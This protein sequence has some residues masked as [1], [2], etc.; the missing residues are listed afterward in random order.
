MNAPRHGLHPRQK[1]R[2]ALERIVAQPSPVPAGATAQVGTF[3]LRT[4]LRL[5]R[6]PEQL[7]DILVT[8]V[9]FVVIFT[10]LF[11]GALAGSPAAYLQFLL[12]GILVQTMVFTTIHTGVNL[13]TDLSK[14]VY[15]RFRSMPLWAPAP[16][17]GAMLGDTLRYTIAAVIVFAIGFVM[18]FRAEGGLSGLL[19]SVL[20][21]NL[22]AFGLGWIFIAMALVIR[23]P[24]T[25]MN[26]S[27]L[28][29]M[30]V[31][32]ASNIYVHADTM[33]PWLSAI[34]AVNPVTLLV[35]ALRTVLQDGTAPLEIA[36]ALIAPLALTVVGA[37]LVMRLY[38]RER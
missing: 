11:G 26:M 19:L 37:P 28:L 17:V 3:A 32:F 23:T 31:T 1:A 5:R 10:Y 33:P 18:G 12:P 6:E 9:M 38:R 35:T 25:L 22:F 21:L 34:V 29:V 15:D 20:L 7:F 36:L 27:W 16:I 2:Q 13:N 8:P 14:G 24:A 4:L 30:P